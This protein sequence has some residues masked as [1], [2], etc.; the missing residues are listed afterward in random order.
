MVKKIKQRPR[1]LFYNDKT[2]RYFYLING[3]KKYLGIFHT[4]LEAHKV[5][6]A[7]H[8][9]QYGSKPHCNCDHCRESQI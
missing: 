4:E 2:D 8:S 1:R 9:K 3:K 5:A 6:V 7:A